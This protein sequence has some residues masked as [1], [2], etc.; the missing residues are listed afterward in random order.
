MIQ[1]TRRSVFSF[2]SLVIMTVLVVP[3][4]ATEVAV[5]NPGFEQLEPSGVVT[6]WRL[7]TEVSSDGASFG[8]ESEVAHTGVGSVELA[9]RGHGTV[10]AESDSVTLEVGK[11]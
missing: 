7:V 6:G 5:S 10:T 3:A 8:G 11:L 9:A 4:M 2:S 1:Q